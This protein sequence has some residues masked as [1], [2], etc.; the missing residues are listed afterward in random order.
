MKDHVTVADITPA[1]KQS[2]Q[3]VLLARAYA[4]TMRARVDKIQREILAEC[5]VR[6]APEHLEQDPTLPQ[7]ITEP[8]DTFL[9][10][11]MDCEDYFA[12]CNTR[13]RAAG[14]K[15][16]SMPDEHCPALVAEDIQRKAEWVLCG[17][18]EEVFGVSQSDVLCAGLDKYR[19]WLDLL[20]KL[21]VNL[22]DFR[23]PLTGKAA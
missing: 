6:T 23:N 12:E 4:E 2:V 11:D 14:L 20:C 13:E 16:D 5:P 21:V 9:G 15:P 7:Y 8:K 18:A 17:A 3:A 1:I 19:Q 10:T 22:P